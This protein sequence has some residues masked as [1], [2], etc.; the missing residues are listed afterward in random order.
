[1][2]NN[3][4]ILTAAVLCCGIAWLAGLSI[5]SRPSD[6]TPADRGVHTRIADTYPHPQ[7]EFTSFSATISAAN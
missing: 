5:V 4:P 1:M 7:S 6:N 2:F 3:R